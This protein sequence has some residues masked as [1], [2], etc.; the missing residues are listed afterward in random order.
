SADLLLPGTA[1]GALAAGVLNINNLRD[2]IS[3]ERTGKITVAVKLGRNGTLV[4][5]FFLL[6]LAMV[7]TVVYM[8]LK[9]GNWYY[10]LSFPLIILNGIQVSRAEN[11]DPYLKTLSLTSLFFVIVFGL[12]LLFR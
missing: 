12:S 9:Q 4:Y 1:C 2:R 10:L 3:D 7:C 11:P 6:S 8:Q 5:H